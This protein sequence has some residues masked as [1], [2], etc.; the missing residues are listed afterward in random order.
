MVKP[1][2]V[3]VYPDVAALSVA[4][5]QR[6]LQ[7]AQAAVAKQGVF[8]VA[9]AGG[10][11]PRGLYTAL[12][13]EPHLRVAIPWAQ[14]HFFFGD[15][16]HVPPDHPDSNYRMANE[17]MFQRLPREWL[18]VHRIPGELPDPAEAAGIYAAEMRRFFE[19]QGLVEDGFPKFDLVLLGMGPDGHTASLFP[20]TPAL[21]E[22]R[23][24]VVANWVEKLNTHR[25]T[26]TLPVLNRAAEI[27]LL[28]AGA[29]K[30]PI[31]A[32][33]LELT[34]PA[35]KYPVQMVQPLKGT[36]RWML[37]KAAAAQLTAI[38]T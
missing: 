12:E 1:Q 38:Q 22:N 27:I 21:Q 30:A 2:L 24:W 8:T 36:K 28:V 31:L 32:E 18:H 15:E 20:G 7:L 3:E 16:R 25:I 34:T 33:V 29:E 10:S 13:T 14:I 11:T 26:M 23:R 37:D 5:G 6:F 35:P 17:A 4:A 19:A 9:L